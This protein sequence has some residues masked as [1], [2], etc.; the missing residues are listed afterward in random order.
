MSISKWGWLEDS[1]EPTLRRVLASGRVERPL[2]DQELD[3]LAIQ[4]QLSFDSLLPMGLML[5]F[6]IMIV[7]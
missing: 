2:D 3:I 4:P 5:V 6:D 7:L 1:S